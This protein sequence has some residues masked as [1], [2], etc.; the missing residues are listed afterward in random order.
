MIKNT[1]LTTH[2]YKHSHNT[3]T[4]KSHGPLVSSSACQWGKWDYKKNDILKWSKTQ[5]LPHIDTN[6][7]ITHTHGSHMVLLCLHLPVNAENELDYKNLTFQNSQKHSLWH[8]KTVK[9]TVYQTHKHQHIINPFSARKGEENMCKTVP[10]NCKV[11]SF[12]F[13]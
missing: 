7:V 1:E 13:F 11:L 6:T 4:W 2:R 3:Y 5:S 9:N 10:G 12:F 8:F